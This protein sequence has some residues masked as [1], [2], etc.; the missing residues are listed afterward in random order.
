MNN[1]K[2]K[3]VLLCVTGSIAAY[4]ACEFIRLLKKQKCHVQVV[5]SKSSE[6]FIGKLSLSAL[7]DNVVLTDEGQTGLEHVKFAI[8]F[9][10]IVILPATANI[11]CK[12]SSGIADDIV[13][14]ILSICVP[15]LIAWFCIVHII[16]FKSPRNGTAAICVLVCFEIF[17]PRT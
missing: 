9:D 3:K 5:M 2:N 4:K 10:I 14:T 7:S 6:N 15:D 12:A 11:I 17:F 1:L 8:D 13:S 16:S